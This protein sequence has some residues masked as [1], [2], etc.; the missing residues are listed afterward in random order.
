MTE[1]DVMLDEEEEI[2]E[3][4]E[5]ALRLCFSHPNIEGIIFWGFW[6]QKMWRKQSALASGANFEV[7]QLSQI[8]VM[9]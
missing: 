7:E 8:T 9:V 6:D 1:F 3:Q 4:M 5:D 2:V